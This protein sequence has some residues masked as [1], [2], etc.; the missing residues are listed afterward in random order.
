MPTCNAK[1]K[2]AKTVKVSKGKVFAFDTNAAAKY[3]AN[4]KCGVTYRK[5]KNCK[6]IKQSTNY[7]ALSNK[8]GSMFFVL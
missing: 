1:G 4:V 2:T 5:M 3:G 7:S 8:R 6:K